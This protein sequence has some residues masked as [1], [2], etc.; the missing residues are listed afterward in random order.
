MRGETVSWIS[1]LRTLGPV[2]FIAYAAGRALDPVPGIAFRSYRLM[3][4]PRSGMPEMPRG[5]GA[6]ELDA[7][8]L[9]RLAR[10]LDL[11]AKT[12]AYRMAQGMT[13][14]GVFRGERPIGC[15]FVTAGAFEEDEVKVRFL[16]PPGAAWDTG[17]FVRREDRASRAFAALWAATGEWLGA[18]GLDWSMSRIAQHNLASL[19]AHRRMNAVEIGR[20]SALRIFGATLRIGGGREIR[21]RVP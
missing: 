20:L 17:L 16:P 6:R 3:A 9:V 11:P 5:H 10:D 18:N 8:D 4:V 12:V 19:H 21:L 1:T 14:L 7:A 13:C 15:T 2:G